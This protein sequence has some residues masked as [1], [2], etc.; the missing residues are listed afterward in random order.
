MLR[1]MFID[2]KILVVIIDMKIFVIG[3]KCLI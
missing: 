3:F 1:K 2:F